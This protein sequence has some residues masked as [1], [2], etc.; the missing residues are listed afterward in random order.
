MELKGSHNDVERWRD[1]L[2]RFGYLPENIRV[3]WDKESV[4]PD[5][6][7]YPNR[8]NIVGLPQ[9]CGR[10]WMYLTVSIDSCAR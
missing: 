8:K 7:D 4:S 5:S 10:V 6:R 1:L 9:L 2:I 3:L